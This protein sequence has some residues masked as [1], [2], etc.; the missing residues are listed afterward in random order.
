LPSGITFRV[1]RKKIEIDVWRTDVMIIQ[2]N[3]MVS[4]VDVGVGEPT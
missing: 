3:G 4:K 1:E 2:I